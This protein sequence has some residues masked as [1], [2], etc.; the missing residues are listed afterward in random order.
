MN[1]KRLIEAERT[2]EFCDVSICGLNRQQ[3]CSGI[4][5]KPDQEKCRREYAEN[6]Q[7]RLKDPL[8]RKAVMQASTRESRYWWSP[9]QCSWSAG[10]RSRRRD[11][12]HVEHE[13]DLSGSPEV[14]FEAA[15]CSIASA[16]EIVRLGPFRS[17]TPTPS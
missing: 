7:N 1:L 6:G 15:L 3:Q 13:L 8:T 5:C 10:F 4:S 16:L 11:D 14:A 12:P 9:Q 2:A 17:T